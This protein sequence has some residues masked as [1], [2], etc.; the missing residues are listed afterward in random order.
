MRRRRSRCVVGSG[1]GAPLRKKL[2]DQVQASKI[3]SHEVLKLRAGQEHQPGGRLEQDEH[4]ALGK[5]GSLPQLGRDDQPPAVSHYYVIRPI[6]V[7]TVPFKVQLWDIT[8][9]AYLQ[10]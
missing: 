6:H 8:S 9:S 5:P 10:P 3:C 2:G 1:F 7:P 4:R